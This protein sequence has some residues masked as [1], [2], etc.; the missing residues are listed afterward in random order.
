M[1]ERCR[2]CGAAI[3]WAS[4]PSGGRMPLDLPS[5]KRVVIGPDGLARVLDT[6]TSHFQTCPNA[7]HHRKPRSNP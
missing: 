5:V 4:T 2:T 7:D 1:S 3:R 6:F